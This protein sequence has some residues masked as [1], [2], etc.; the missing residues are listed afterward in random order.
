M[1]EDFNIR[2]MQLI[3]LE[4]LKE[5]DRICKKHDIK[6]FLCGGTMLGAVRH[7]GFIPWDDDID[8]ML[9]RN[10]YEKLINICLKELDTKY[11]LQTFE[12]D[13][14]Y[15]KM[16]AKIR[17]NNTIFKEMTTRKINMHHGIYID[18]F[19]LDNIP[20]SKVLLQIH[21]IILSVFD[22]FRLSSKIEY[23]IESP[24]FLRKI[25]GYIMFPISKLIVHRP[26]LKLIDFIAKIFRK[27]ETKFVS[28]LYGD[29]I[30]W[31]SKPR[32]A[33]LRAIYESVE[34]LKFE[35]GYFPVPKR[36]DEYLT[37]VYGDYMQLPPVEER[38][39]HHHIVQID[40]NAINK[41]K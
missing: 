22:V 9:L 14:G 37:A 40:L 3:Q 34:Y 16:Y 24:S 13:K 28:N 2:E 18:I 33:Q 20:D 38:C 31:Y 15:I 11:F 36:W 21:K 12:T 4:M 41:N 32:Q 6:Y 10:D 1:I 8:V 26:F 27:K 29:T 7:E 39:L 25:V 19:P 17:C 30:R 5:F 35:D 23:F